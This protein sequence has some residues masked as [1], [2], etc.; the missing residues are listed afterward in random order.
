MRLLDV[1]NE[2]SIYE[3]AKIF[4]SKKYLEL[5]NYHK[6]H[7][8]FIFILL[9]I[10]LIGSVGF[11]KIIYNFW[12]N[13]QFN[14]SYTLL[15]VISIEAAFIILKE[16]INITMK[17]INRFIKI[18]IIDFCFISFSMFISFYLLNLGYPFIAHF[19][20]ILVQTFI[21]LIITTLITLKFYKSIK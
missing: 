15:L 21:A 6:R 14:L 12:L 1:F 3:Y 16:T 20:I 17:S 9:I 7:T 18:S 11:G 8:L 5:E 2:V 4:A 13:N 10:F 19:L